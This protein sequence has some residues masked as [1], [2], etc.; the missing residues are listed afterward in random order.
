MDNYH[1]EWTV[2]ATDWALVLGSYFGEENH[3]CLLRTAG[4]IRKAMGRLDSTQ[5]ECIC[6]VHEAWQGKV[7]SGGYQVLW[8]PW[9]VPQHN[10]SKC[11]S[12]VQSTS[13]FSTRSGLAMTGEKT[14]TWDAEV[15]VGPY[16]SSIP[17][18]TQIPYGRCSTTAH[19]QYMLRVN[20]GT[21]CPV[22]WLQ[23]RMGQQWLTEVISCY[24][25]KRLSPEA[26][27]EQRKWSNCGTVQRQH[28]RDISE[29][30]LQLTWAR[31]IHGSHLH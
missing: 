3:L 1:G 6:H 18:A 26:D 19:P 27:S 28:I 2:R 11:S 16:T 20:V 29:M 31:S 23:N 17:E 10:M 5:E 22:L 7:Y 13:E 15:V 21:T 12:A 4:T 25:Q 9:S 14:Q 30:F 8:Q 24:G